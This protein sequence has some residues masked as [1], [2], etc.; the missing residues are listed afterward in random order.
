MKAIFMVGEQRSGSNLLRVILNQSDKIA[1]PHPPHILQRLMPL[2]SLYGGFNNEEQFMTLIKDVCQ[3]VENNPVTWEGTRLDRQVVRGRCRENSLIAVYGAIMDIYAESQ[4]ASA[5]LCKSMQNI[6]WAEQLDEYFDE[7]K[8]L[9]LYRD[10]RDVSLSFS[11]AV[12]GEKHPFFIARQWT[13]LQ[14]LCLR[15]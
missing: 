10:P 2:V 5:W 11:K 4:N 14:Q 7:P 9:Y 13:E 15:H 3:L 8:Y 6:R 12:I 1:A